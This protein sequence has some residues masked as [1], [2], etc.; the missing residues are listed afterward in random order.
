MQHD[1][2]R[3]VNRISRKRGLQLLFL[4]WTCIPAPVLAQTDRSSLNDLA[5]NWIQGE[6][7][8][9][10]ICTIDGSP[11]RGLRRLEIETSRSS[12][13]AARGR[14]RFIDIEA[15]E[16]TRCVSELGS[17]APNLIGA[18]EI[19]NIS[20]KPRATAKRD[21]RSELK[22]N[23]GFDFNI[24]AGS[25]QVAEV[26]EGEDP[27]EDLNFRGGSVRI[28]LIR[29]GSD[30]SRL[31][32]DVPSRRKILLEIKGPSGFDLRLPLAMA[33]PAPQ[34]RPAGSRTR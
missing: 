33:D 11:A 8:S 23:K 34:N 1:T 14:I 4:L 24:V 26:R 25:L 10:L 13:E 18:I 32:A 27:T 20:T 2:L 29:R 17:R 15:D 22:R 3:R 12:G 9:P 7:V 5:L 21:F 16:A 6:Y 19:R 31:L 28:H 30:A